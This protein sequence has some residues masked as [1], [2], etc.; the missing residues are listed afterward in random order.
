MASGTSAEV[1]RQW[2]MV[3]C[4][5]AIL[6]VATAIGA[7]AQ[8][9]GAGSSANQLESAASDGAEISQ[10]I[11]RI[12]DPAQREQLLNDLKLLR[13]ALPDADLED[14]D[15]TTIL[16]I[17]E[18]IDQ[19]A[20]TAL[21]LGEWISRLPTVLSWLNFQLDN[22]TRREFWIRLGFELAI[23]LGVAA[24]L[25]A[26]VRLACDRRSPAFDADKRTFARFVLTRELLAL[27]A[28]SL[29]F[30]LAVVWFQGDTAL[31]SLVQQIALA[32]LLFR[33]IKTVNRLL[34]APGFQNARWLPLTDDTAQ[35]AHNWLN[36]SGLVLVIAMALQLIAR[37][38]TIPLLISDVLLHLMFFILVVVS[39]LGLFSVLPTIAME[40]VAD[41]KSP[42]RVWL[43]ERG[44]WIG[45]ITAILAYAVW[46]LGFPGGAAFMVR[47]IGG[48]ILLVIVVLFALRAVRSNPRPLSQPQ[49]MLTTAD[50][51]AE[52]GD[53]TIQVAIRSRYGSLVPTL[54]RLIIYA[55][56][57]VALAEIWN[58]GLVAWMWSDTG[59][60]LIVVIVRILIVVA[61]ALAIAEIVS[62]WAGRYI[63]ATDALGQPRHSNR[64]RTLAN[65]ARNLVLFGLAIFSIVFSLGQIGVDA[66][67]LL[68]GAGVIGLAIGFGSQK[69]VQDLINGV[70]I[71]LG[72]TISVGDVISLGGLAGVVESMSMRT[73]TLRSYNGDVHTIPYSSIDAIT[74]MTKG[75]SYAEFNIGVGYE[76]N[77]DKVQD[78][79]VS[80]FHDMRRVRT[81]RWE[82]MGDIEMAGV[83]QLGDS[84]VVIKG[85]IKT[86]PGSQWMVRREF[87][88]RVKLKF[89]ELGIEIPFPKRSVYITA[90]NPD[91]ANPSP[92]VE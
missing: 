43:G 33:S 72:D 2:L 76:E 40:L 70:F 53:E 7:H 42:L 14:D 71:L 9:G 22:K 17:D 81:F 41:E 48:T 84:A 20:S 66:T 38:L 88:R 11:E 57:A 30:V 16:I 87:T 28:L 85:R 69:L 4:V 39:S 12:E 59:K 45:M 62:H 6:L 52:T 63:K 78:V 1:W 58:L 60:A 50:D 37:D 91:P 51:D 61:I 75:F 31:A 44:P 8:Q 80:I 49:P 77:V 5:A 19:L 73:I 90:T 23:T 79:L 3:F 13:Q 24:T 34:F 46:S 29:A 86:K 25:S 68:A 74:N 18:K 67:A 89:D 15:Q 55:G 65:F 10:L 47:A 21:R 27:L 56:A 82:M 92:A 83:D 32:I 26:F 64:N 36:R 54:F 35:Q